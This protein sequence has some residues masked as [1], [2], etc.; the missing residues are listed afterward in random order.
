MNS[1]HNI[2]LLFV[3]Y[4]MTL[5]CEKEFTPVTTYDGPQVVVEGYIYNGPNAL[6]PFV[7]LT[8]SIEYT[9]NVSLDILNDIFIHDAQV[10]VFDGTNSVQL[11]ELCVSDLQ[12]LPVFLQNAISQAIG[13]P[14][15]DSIDFDICVYTDIFGLLGF[16]IN[17]EEGKT[18]DLEIITDDF[19]TITATTTLPSLVPLD[20]LKYN[21]HPSYPDND[22]LVELEAYFTDPIGPNYYRSFTQRNDEQMYPAYTRGT[23]GSVS[24]DNIFEGQSFSFGL[25]RGSGPFDDLDI[26]TYG[27]FWRGDTVIVRTASL[28]YEHFRFW[29]TLEYNS[30]AQGPFG[31]YTR[32]ESNI[33]GGLGIW[34]G[35]TYDDYTITIPE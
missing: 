18:Y 9:S 15:L 11:P 32:I 29:Q 5:S 22:S 3:L 4:F 25:L 20:S 16:G 30:G 12:F 10:T 23:V 34:G 7:I 13:L 27:Y 35:I 31:T 33:K 26:D 28:D 17:I 6:P 19:G 21:N 2:L 24:D 14:T 1:F 8:K